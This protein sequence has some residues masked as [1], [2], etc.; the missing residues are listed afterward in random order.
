MNIPD[1]LEKNDSAVL[2]AINSHM[3]YDKS[4]INRAGEGARLEMINSGWLGMPH[5]AGHTALGSE[6]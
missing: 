5:R 6:G 2:D 3:Y 1:T 4:W